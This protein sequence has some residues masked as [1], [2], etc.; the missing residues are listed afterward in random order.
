MLLGLVRSVAFGLLGFR[1]VL[2]WAEAGIEFQRI[3]RHPAQRVD[4][5]PTVSPRDR[6]NCRRLPDYGQNQPARRVVSEPRSWRPVPRGIGHVGVVK[7]SK[8]DARSRIGRADRNA[9]GQVDL[10]G[11]LD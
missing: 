7:F 10:G 5:S 2:Y 11:R 6:P 9:L 4:Q 3:A 8:G 1:G